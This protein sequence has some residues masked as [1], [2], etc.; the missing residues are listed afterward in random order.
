MYQDDLG[1]RIR[2][3]VWKWPFL[4]PLGAVSNAVGHC[5]L[6]L[7]PCKSHMA[8][9]EPGTALVNGLGSS[10]GKLFFPFSMDKKRK[11]TQILRS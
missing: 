5:C 9:W 6:S 10:I 11:R 8:V 2:P 3:E 1:K 4:I 7:L